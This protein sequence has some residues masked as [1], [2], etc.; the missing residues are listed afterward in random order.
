MRVTSVT[1]VARHVLL[2]IRELRVDFTNRGDHHPG[3]VFFRIFVRR[4]LALDVAVGATTLIR[5]AERGDKNV[6][7]RAIGFRSQQLQILWRSLGF[8]FAVWR[9]SEQRQR[10]HTRC[11]G[12]GKEGAHG[13]IIH[14]HLGLSSTRMLMNDAP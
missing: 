10:D 11:R 1:G 13:A 6:H 9:L 8:C 12:N 4:H 14:I 2:A 7:H 5:Q 3:D